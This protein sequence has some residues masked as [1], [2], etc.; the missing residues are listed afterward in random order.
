MNRPVATLSLCFFLTVNTASKADAPS[1]S[2]IAAQKLFTRLT[3]VPILLTDPRLATMKQAIE[4]G[5]WSDA[6]HIA[7]DDSNFYNTTLKDFAAAMSN[8][9][10]TPIVELDDFQAMIIGVTRDDADARTLLTGNF[11]YQGADSL[12]LPAPATSG[13]DHYSQMDQ[14][15][16]DLKANLVRH[17]PQ[18]D[19][20]PESAGLLTTRGWAKAH[21][22]AGTNRR[23]VEYTLREFLCTPKEKWRDPGLPDYR[24]RRDVDRKPGGVPNTY[25]TTCRSCHAPM[26][27]LGGAFASYD[28]ANDDIVYYG[29]FGVAPKMNKNA[30]HFPAGFVTTESSWVNLLTK[31]QNEAFGWTGPLHGMGVHDFGVMISKAGMFPKCMVQRVFT[32]LCRQDLSGSAEGSLVQRLSD[33]FVA[34]GYKLRGL[35]EAVAVDPVCMG[36]NGPH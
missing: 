18:W 3:G 23:A 22:I 19:N 1:P 14:A 29:Q 8:R 35:F 20:L 9:A 17:E 31:D 11:R 2:Q 12:G 27:G 15:Q 5:K 26:D 36:T 34:N 25:Q 24:V 21:L 30:D 4:N 13:N 28:F 10:E 16:T 7:T 6:A 33:Q 32:K